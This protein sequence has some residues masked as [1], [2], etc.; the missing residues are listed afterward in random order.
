MTEL[1]GIDQLRAAVAAFNGCNESFL[2]RY[3][4]NDLLK[5]WRAWR[6]SEWDIYPDQWSARQ[7]R[8]AICLGKPPRFNADD[9]PAV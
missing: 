8:D 6:A 2:Q 3:D 1:T 7:L 4:A 9:S 5:L